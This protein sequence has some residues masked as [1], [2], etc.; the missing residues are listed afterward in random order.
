[1]DCIVHSTKDYKLVWKQE[2][3]PSILV[4]PAEDRTT[5]FENGTL[6]IM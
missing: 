3:A 6:K 1:M 4:E 5:T 2:I